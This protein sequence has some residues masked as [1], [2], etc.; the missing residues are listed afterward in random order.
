MPF[1]ILCRLGCLRLVY[2][3]DA[4]KNLAETALCDLN[5]IVGLQ[6]EPKPRWEPFSTV[7]RVAAAGR[8]VPPPA[9]FSET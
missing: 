3:L 4:V 7:S 2:S 6:I 9:V 5:I 1:E 8:G